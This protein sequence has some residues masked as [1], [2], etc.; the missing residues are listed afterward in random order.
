M[1]GLEYEN[2]EKLILLIGGGTIDKYYF[3]QQKYTFM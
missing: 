3:F 1:D 2:G